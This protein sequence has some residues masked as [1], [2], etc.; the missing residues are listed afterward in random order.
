MADLT[1]DG[2]PTTIVVVEANRAVGF[3][4]DFS[5]DILFGS[6]NPTTMN[7]HDESQVRLWN[8]IGRT[9][10]SKKSLQFEQDGSS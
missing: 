1:P 9:H 4:E 10:A 5:L 7:S 3:C 8:R 2:V 6:N